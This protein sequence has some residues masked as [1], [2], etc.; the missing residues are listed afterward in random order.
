MNPTQ[1]IQTEGDSLCVSLINGSKKAAQFARLVVDTHGINADMIKVDIQALVDRHFSKAACSADD[2]RL[3][4]YASF[5]GAF[6]PKRINSYLVD[7]KGGLLNISFAD[8]DGTPKDSK[9]R[10]V[11]VTYRTPEQVEQEAK[12]AARDESK[13]RADE[14]HA[15]E[16]D[17]LTQE[18]TRAALTAEDVVK[19]LQGYM[20]E[21]TTLSEQDVVAAWTTLLTQQ[22]EHAEGIK[23]AEQAKQ[24][25]AA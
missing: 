14:I 6:V 19:I 4:A 9:A 18:L 5:R 25:K 10:F 21:L 1:K 2:A 20:P 17:K 11:T 22:A 7:G 3:A 15:A 8:P 12:Q 16:Q 23:K 24:S 13:A